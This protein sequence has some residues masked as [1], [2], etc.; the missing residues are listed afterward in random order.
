MKQ[1]A[2]KSEEELA[3]IWKRQQHER[4]FADLGD[5]TTRLLE[6][7]ASGDPSKGGSLG[8]GKQRGAGVERGV[9]AEGDGNTP[10]GEGERNVQPTQ[11]VLHVQGAEERPQLR[12]V[13]EK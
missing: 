5:T 12:S 10:D 1:Y 8:R 3:A 13:Q 4:L 2:L 9:A 7:F 6:F 11:E